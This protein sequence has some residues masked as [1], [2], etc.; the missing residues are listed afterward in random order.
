MLSCMKS[1]T[2]I[3]TGRNKN[4]PSM[5][6]VATLGGT[7]WQVVFSPDD[8]TIAACSRDHTITIFD[9]KTGVLETKLRGHTDGVRSIAFSPNGIR[10]ASGSADRSV[11]IWDL[12][13]GDIVG[14]PLNGHSGEVTS[15]VY[16]PDGRFIASRSQ[17]SEIRTWDAQSG[18]A[19][20]VMP[21]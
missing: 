2:L 12:K 8:Q 16:S 1:D 13:T 9:A 14:K 10:L 15:V 19:V 6:W 3:S 18:D 11:F 21:V 7:V 20:R 17:V 4:W 5:L